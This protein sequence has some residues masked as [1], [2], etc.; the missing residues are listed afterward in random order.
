MDLRIRKATAADKSVIAEILR[1]AAQYKLA[2][3]DHTWPE[4]FGDRAIDHF[5]DDITTYIAYIG[6]EPVGTF[7]IDW[8]D[9]EFWGERS[10][11]GAYLHK[12]ALKE[13]VHG[14][15]LGKTLIDYAAAETA[16]RGRR[17]LRLDCSAD[18]AGLCA[19]YEK[20]GFKRAGI[21]NFEKYPQYRAALYERPLWQLSDN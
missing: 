11:E 8:S 15:G 18:N 10:A 9:E 7:G 12:I 19:Y 20:L 21:R 1:E 16:R 6:E 2:R 14:R 17:F 4:R 3:G 5:V 13:G